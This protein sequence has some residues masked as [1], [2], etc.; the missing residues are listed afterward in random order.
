LFGTRAI[1]SAQA[2]GISRGF[3][4]DYLGKRD[5]ACEARVVVSRMDDSLRLRLGG[6]CLELARAQ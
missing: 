4:Q 1:N 3:P 5:E 6:S 2:T